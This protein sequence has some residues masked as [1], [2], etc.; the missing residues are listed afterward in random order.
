MKQPA[1]HKTTM[2]ICFLLIVLTAVADLYLLRPFP[3]KCYGLIRLENG[4]L[5][6][7]GDSPRDINGVPSWL[8]SGND[9]WNKAELRQASFNSQSK[10]IWFR[11]TLPDKEIKDPHIIFP[12]YEQCIDV[13]LENKLIYRY[14]WD[15]KNSFSIGSH[16]NILSL[17]PE[18]KGK[19]LSIRV[20]S[21]SPIFTG[22]IQDFF[23]GTG[24][25]IDSYKN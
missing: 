17:S 16:W 9:G 10:F 24:R 8:L 13:Y 23:M 19:I 15:N 18:Y 1:R 14:G 3:E 21:H 5:C 2:L 4:W 11:T 6:R 20:Y 12:T 25:D 7:W 22:E